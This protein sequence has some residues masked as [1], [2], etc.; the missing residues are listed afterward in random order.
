[1]T[2]RRNLTLGLVCLFLVAMLARIVGFHRRAQQ[3]A[4]V[5]VPAAYAEKNPGP[6]PRDGED[7]VTSMSGE[8]DRGD[9]RKI[10]NRTSGSVLVTGAAGFIGAHASLTLR[11]L[12][13][14]VVGI[15]N[16]NDYYDV[17]LKGLRAK[18]IQKA[19]ATMVVGDLCNRTLMRGVFRDNVFTHV[20]HLA[21]QAGVRYS[22]HN[23]YVYGTSNVM[24]TINLLETMV[25]SSTA[26]RPIFVYASSSSI[27]GNTA[28]SP[29]RESEKT[30]SPISTYAATKR[31]TELLAHAYHSLYGVRS[32]GLR[33][34]T[35]YGPL[36]RPDM[37]V[38]AWTANMTRNKPIKV[39]QPDDGILM[40]DFTYID[41]I[42]DG[43]VAAMDY[44]ADWAIFNLGRGEPQ[45]VNELVVRLEKELGVGA[46]VISRPLP[47]GDVRVTYADTSY[48]G[49]VLGYRPNISIAEGVKRF[50]D[51]YKSY[52]K[53]IAETT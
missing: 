33:F 24:C 45:S 12:G 27:Y 15:D 19:G 40:R 3:G 1:M 47:K 32:T 21:A 35:V 18:L 34:F 5:V 23:P 50:V 7:S 43:V 42:I 44:A 38:W 13:F 41:D 20:L 8:P 46:K 14:D 28:K 10:F 2:R 36:G 6:V 22:I 37:A 51:W 31:A 30:D 39:Y 17:R 4:R 11:T 52:N 53:M 48:A 29:F 9:W 25:R 16:M 49:R 26:P